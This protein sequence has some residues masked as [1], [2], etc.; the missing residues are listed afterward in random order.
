MRARI[1]L[2]IVSMLASCGANNAGG[3]VDSTPDSQT[4]GGELVPPPHGFQIASPM[5]DLAAYEEITYCYY[6]RTSNPSDV[7]IKKWASHMT[8]GSHDVTVYLTRTELQKAGTFSAQPCGIT[9]DGVGPLWAYAAQDPDAEVSLP[10]DDGNGTAVGQPIPAGQPGFLQMHFLNP[11]GGA[12]RAHVQI[13]GY[14]HDDGVAVTPAGPFV[15]YTTNI[16]LSPGSATAPTTGTVGNPCPVSPSLK[17]FSISTHTHKQGVHTF[18]KDGTTTVL[19]NTSW[20]HPATR[21]WSAPSFYS[22]TSGK[23]TYQCE[24]Q[25]PNNR[26][27]QT[28]DTAAVDETCMAIGF[29][30]PSPGGAGA[31]CLDG[32]IVN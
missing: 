32:S 18:V 1:V 12:L 29:F 4:T 31:L 19:D 9:T 25:N 6:F 26:R 21:T 14:A 8:P 7:A 22:F 28:G 11:T 24:Y 3:P 23:L 5:V 13:N 27:I 17:F 15:T 2:V 30:F 10:P 20:D 16:D